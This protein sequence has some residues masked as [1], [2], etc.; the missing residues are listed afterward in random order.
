MA[1]GA[2]REDNP[3]ALDSQTEQR[4]QALLADRAVPLLLR[5]LQMW[6]RGARRTSCTACGACMAASLLALWRSWAP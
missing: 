3:G 1:Y 6:R 2:L 5:C 4:L